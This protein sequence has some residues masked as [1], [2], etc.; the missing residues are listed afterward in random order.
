ME[1]EMNSAVKTAFDNAAHNYDQARRQLIPCFDD[2]YGTALSLIP[3]QTYDCFRVLDLGAGT[4]LLSL[5]VSE[6][7]PNARTTLLD[8]SEE[9]L[10]KAK[11]RFASA[12]D[13]FTF[14]V[15]DYSELLQGEFDVIVSALSIHHLS[16]ADKVR[17]FHTI[18]N[19]LPAGGLFINADQ[20]LGCSAQVE[21]I[22]RATWLAQVRS[23]GISDADLSAAL[24]RMKQDK[25]APLEPQL[26][27]LRQAGFGTV[28][29]WYKNYSFAVFSGRKD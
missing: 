6:K 7:F 22:Y 20:V 21:Q 29:C 3:Y 5:L 23:R 4:G 24:E 18:F 12:G 27:W 19:A 13:R 14:V 25:M 26:N 2:F 1:N 10:A 15:A 11:E 16:D 17:L 8:I 9:M 28:N